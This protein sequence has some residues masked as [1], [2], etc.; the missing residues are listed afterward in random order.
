MKV[1]KIVLGQLINS[2]HSFSKDVIY[3]FD[4]IESKP[5]T[6]K[7]DDTD[8]EINKE[9]RKP[10]DKEKQEWLKEK[11]RLF[12]TFGIAT[13]ST[14][15]S[16]KGMIMHG[17]YVAVLN[18]FENKKRWFSYEN[19]KNYNYHA[20]YKNYSETEQE[21]INSVIKRKYNLPAKICT[22]EITIKEGD[23]NDS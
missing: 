23:K 9:L 6:I 19:Y 15:Y 13:R 11:L 1:D 21:F 22:V 17:N 7:F 4:N 20:G 18:Y 3:N 16:L 14:Y 12:N 8:I 10:N 2:F 5:L